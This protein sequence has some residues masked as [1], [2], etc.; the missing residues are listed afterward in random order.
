M[1]SPLPCPCY[2]AI[3]GEGITTENPTCQLCKRELLSETLSDTLTVLNQKLQ[4]QENVTE[5]LS[6]ENEG[7]REKV[8]SLQEE[9]SILKRD[10]E[11]LGEKLIREAEE[12]SQ[13]LLENDRITQELNEL[14]E[15]LFEEANTLVSAESKKRYEAETSRERAVS[16][17]EEARRRLELEQEVVQELKRKIELYAEREED[18]AHL[19]HPSPPASPSPSP[20]SPS[21][22][23]PSPCSP[24]SF[25]N[26]ASLLRRSPSRQNLE[27]VFDARLFVEFQEFLEEF[28][29][30][31]EVFSLRFIKRCISEDINPCLG[32]LGKSLLRK[33]LSAF[34]ENNFFIELL[35]Q[36]LSSPDT[37]AACEC[38]RRCAYRFRTDP[39]DPWKLIDRFCRD[40]IVAVGDFF[41]FLRHLH[42]GLVP[43]LPPEEM[44]QQVSR[45]RKQI[46]YARLGI[47]H[48]FPSSEKQ[49]E[50]S[51]VQL[52]IFESI[53]LNQSNDDLE[54]EDS[55]ST[56]DNKKERGR[57][58]SRSSFSDSQSLN[59]FSKVQRFGRLESLIS[60]PF[61]H[62]TGRDL[63]HLE[64]TFDAM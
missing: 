38:R 30:T 60:H 25:D 32:Y 29:A 39:K 4:N 54:S 12:R 8:A 7:L 24:A 34:W 22:C 48:L 46:F 41:S 26:A 15:K 61:F 17:L 20:C 45:L 37:C 18:E 59:P 49:F 21:P 1:A 55:P 31:S 44:F 35:P 36:K 2:F 28:K 19:F 51:S 43:S 63:T 5:L 50:G 6:Q 40:R 14:T 56:P 11:I 9:A 10:G 23:S 33:F 62:K 58:N 13:L 57:A 53:P 47:L 64:E 16:E 27:T 3:K 52:E 42:Q